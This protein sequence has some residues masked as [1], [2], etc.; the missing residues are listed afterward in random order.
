[1]DLD[2]IPFA[3]WLPDLPTLGSGS[4][5]IKNVIPGSAGYKQF[6]GLSVY[7]GALT[8]YSRG[9]VS[10]KDTSGTTY[11]FS[12]DETKLYSL[13]GTTWS[14]V[15]KTAVGAYATASAEQWEFAKWGDKCIATN[16]TNNVQIKSL[17]SGNFGDLTGSPP[18]ARHI[19][20]V[21][22]FV[23]LGNVGSVPNKIQWS[24][25]NDETA[26][27]ASAA[28]QSD[29][30]T[31]QGNGGDVQAIVGGD[32]G[33]VFQQHAIWQMTYIGSPVVFQLDQ[34]E[35]S[36]GAFAPKSVIKVGSIIY[37]LADDGFYKLEG[38]SSVPIGANKIDKTFFNDL[39]S[40]NSHRINAIADISN[41]LIVWA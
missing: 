33:F 14:D 20:V 6:L 35:G 2:P 12:G 4:P 24:G 16:F 3:E 25:I 31:L 1:M 15:S 21:R 32:R 5:S 27:T 9:A 13:S 22:D 19:A 18:K 10:M 37:F 39:D 36:R 30:Q 40:T 29:S 7:S 23:V 28:T 38:G 11:N 8:A 26:W 41:K 34:I 17:T